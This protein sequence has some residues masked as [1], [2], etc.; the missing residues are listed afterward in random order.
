MRPYLLATFA[1][2]GLMGETTIEAQAAPHI[3]YDCPA[4]ASGVV[5]HTGDAGWTATNQSSRVRDAR[6]ES[7][8]GQVALVCTYQIFGTEYWIHRRPPVEYPNC[9]RLE[10]GGYRFYCGP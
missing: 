2:L 4:E 5:S 8:G 6:L 7:I 10:G 1:F 9:R 3:V